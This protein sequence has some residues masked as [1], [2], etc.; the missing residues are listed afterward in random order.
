M[1]KQAPQRTCVVC[2]ERA[3]KGA[4]LRFVIEN[5]TAQFDADQIKDGR[6]MY[7]HPECYQKL[8]NRPLKGHWKLR[9][10]K[11]PRIMK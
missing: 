5:G 11:L 10:L 1:T 9:N 4:L 7:L 6:G 8:D 2:R 3:V